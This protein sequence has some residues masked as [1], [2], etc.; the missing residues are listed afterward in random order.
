VVEDL[1]KSLFLR[2]NR[3]NLRFDPDQAFIFSS[4]AMAEVLR[5]I[6]PWLC[7][8]VIDRLQ[9]H[10]S[11]NSVYD[12]EGTPL[13][14]TPLIESGR[15]VGKLYD[16]YHAT[17]ENRLSTGNWRRSRM[18]RPATIGPWHLLMQPGE[19]STDD[20]LKELSEGFFIDNI[21]SISPSAVP[22]TCW[23][24]GSGW[25]VVNQEVTDRFLEFS[26]EVSL[27]DLLQ[28]MVAVGRHITAFGDCSAAAALYR[29]QQ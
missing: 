7:S 12:L 24:R 13:V 17:K 28:R 29:K 25:Q 3:L 20:L 1:A 27:M 4:H 16:Y 19:A 22:G 5:F 26:F 21:F 9:S 15:W 18:E 14:R 8:D 2:R 23:I 10:S 11:S 6:G